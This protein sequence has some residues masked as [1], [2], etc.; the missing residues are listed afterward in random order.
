MLGR[1]LSLILAFPAHIDRLFFPFVVF[2]IPFPALL[3][4]PGGANHFHGSNGSSSPLSGLMQCSTPVTVTPV[5]P[6][7]TSLTSLQQPSEDQQT[8]VTLNQSLP[9]SLGGED[10]L[11]SLGEDEGITDFFSSVDLDQLPIDMPLI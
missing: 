7:P 3:F 1:C 5:F 4:F 6:L 10:Y 11:L 2:S 8:F 9:L